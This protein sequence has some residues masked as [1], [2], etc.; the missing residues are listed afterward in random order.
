MFMILNSLKA[1]QLFEVLYQPAPGKS[2]EHNIMVPY[3]YKHL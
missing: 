1:K 3:V 2:T